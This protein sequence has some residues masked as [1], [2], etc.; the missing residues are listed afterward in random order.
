MYISLSFLQYMVIMIQDRV[1]EKKGT[2]VQSGCEPIS[3]AC[4][5]RANSD[6]LS[7]VTRVE[8]DGG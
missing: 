2:I 4:R 3:V 8:A 1:K 5:P 6:S 7:P